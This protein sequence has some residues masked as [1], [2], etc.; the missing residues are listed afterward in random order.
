MGNNSQVVERRLVGRVRPERPRQP[1]PINRR[2][3]PQYEE[4]QQPNLL[5]G[6]RLGQRPA[7]NQCAERTEQAQAQCRGVRRSWQRIDGFRGA[8]VHGKPHG[9]IKQQ[10]VFPV[11]H[12]DTLFLPIWTRFWPRCW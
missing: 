4:S 1:K 12:M 3:G 6:S 7:M 8:G 10:T 2:I 5:A 9:L 11:R